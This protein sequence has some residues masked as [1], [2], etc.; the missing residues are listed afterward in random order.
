[1]KTG[2][3]IAALALLIGSHY[4]AYR[5]AAGHYEAQAIENGW[6]HRVRWADGGSEIKWHK[7]PQ[8]GKWI[9]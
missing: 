6:A 1:M 8:T 7:H 3:V 5:L 2:L 4:A 9:E